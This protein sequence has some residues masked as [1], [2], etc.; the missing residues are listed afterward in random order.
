MS[1]RLRL[2]PLSV[3]HA[4]G[5][6]E[7]LADASMYEYTGGEAPSLEQLQRRYSAQSVGH[8]EDGSQG[9]FN[10]IVKPRDSDAPIGFVQTTIEQDG[11]ELVADIGWVISPV[12][13][14]QG[15]ASEATEA[16]TSRLRS[17]GVSRVRG[18]C[19]SRASRLYGRRAKAGTSSD[20]P[21]GGRR[22]PLGV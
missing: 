6:V 2:V 15:R 12:H 9:W 22:D 17:R 18:V 11:P 16:M 1:V 7:V 20:I 10:W 19:A 14:G 3:E 5:M 8:S 4:L 21:D 13:Q